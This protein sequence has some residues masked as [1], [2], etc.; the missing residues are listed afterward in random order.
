[1]AE[2]EL[3]KQDMLLKLLKMTTSD[4]DGEALVAI[5]K[6]NGLL[7]TAG[8]DWDKL[9]AGKIK[10]VADPFAGVNAQFKNVNKTPPPA[11]A[12]P[13]NYA[14]GAAPRAQQAYTRAQAKPQPQRQ[15]PPPPQPLSTKPNIFPQHCYCCGIAVPAQAGWIFDPSKHNSRAKSKWQVLCTGCVKTDPNSIYPNPHPRQQA[16]PQP[17]ATPNLNDL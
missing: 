9:I 14:A 16:K 8:W 3:P 10:V 17:Q 12:A 13:P 11:A 15:P 4:N 6:A 2:A 5:R 7:K 1:M